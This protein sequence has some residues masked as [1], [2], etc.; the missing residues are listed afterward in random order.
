MWWFYVLCAVLSVIV[1]GGAFGWY[2]R[3]DIRKA[4]LDYRRRWT[5]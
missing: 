1:W 3:K 4:W 2:A 5:T